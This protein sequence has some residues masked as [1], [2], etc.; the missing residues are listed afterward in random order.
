MNDNEAFL[1]FSHSVFLFKVF[2]VFYSLKKQTD[3]SITAFFFNYF[4]FSTAVAFRHIKLNSLKLE[5]KKCFG[6]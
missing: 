5:L 4:L 2:L 6:W 1:L 3:I